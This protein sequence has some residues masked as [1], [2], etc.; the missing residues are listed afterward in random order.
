MAQSG[1]PTRPTQKS[2]A[3]AANPN[4]TSVIAQASRNLRNTAP[5]RTPKPQKTKPSKPKT[6]AS[7]YLG[8]ANL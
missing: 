5:Y 6:V 1:V 3:A 2:R 8:S 4:A 7:T